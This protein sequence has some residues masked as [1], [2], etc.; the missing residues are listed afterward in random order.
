MRKLTFPTCIFVAAA[1]GGPAF[2][3]NRTPI[4][5]LENHVC[6]AIDAPEVVMMDFKHPIPLKD[7]PSD[8][9]A[10]FAS[11]PGVLAVNPSDPKLNGYVKSMN[12]ALRPGWV[13]EKW[14]K[15]YSTVHPG[16][17]CTPYLMS[18]G[19][20]GFVFGRG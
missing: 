2:A 16:M 19:K 5:P 11:A 17:T 20:L 1:L 6:M 3:A 4:K 14:V 18:D 12:Y 9:A 8:S 10:A 15:P 7:E 13:P